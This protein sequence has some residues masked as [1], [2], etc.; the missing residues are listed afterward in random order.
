MLGRLQMTIDDSIEA[1]VRLA[2]RG[3]KKPGLPVNL[4]CQVQSRFNT[5]ALERE[6]KAIVRR[7]TGTE[8]SLFE[9]KEN[10][11]CKV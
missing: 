9:D 8:N 6:I 7:Q 4:Y 1:Y 11:S 5:K 10:E 2:D 3:F